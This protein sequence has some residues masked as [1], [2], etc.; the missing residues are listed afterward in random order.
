MTLRKDPF[1]I[2]RIPCACCIRLVSSLFWFLSV[3]EMPQPEHECAS[4]LEYV[5]FFFGGV[6]VYDHV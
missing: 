5:S 1:Y 4:V 2:D 6:F 3:V